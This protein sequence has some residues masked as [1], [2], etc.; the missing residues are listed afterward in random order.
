[1]SF[2]PDGQQFASGSHDRAVRLWDV[3]TGQCLKILKGRMSRVRSVSF[4]LDS[5]I[6]ASGSNDEAIRLWEVKTG[7]EL[8]PLVIAK[9]YQDMNIP[10]TTGLTETQR[11]TLVKLGAFDHRLL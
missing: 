10:G 1:V 3:K 9:P 4:S 8:H 7:K 5:K 2:S 6:L 11:A